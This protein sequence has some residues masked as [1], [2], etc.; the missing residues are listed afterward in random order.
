MKLIRKSFFRIS[1]LMNL[2]KL[3]FLVQNF[4]FDSTMNLVVFY[5]LCS[6]TYAIS[7]YRCTFNSFCIH[8]CSGVSSFAVTEPG[9]S[10]PGRKKTE[11]CFVSFVGL[12]KI[13]LDKLPVGLGPQQ[14]AR[15]NSSFLS[16]DNLLLIFKVVTH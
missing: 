2:C 6:N 5:V 16:R 4:S 15:E 1:H 9:S 7:V 13:P 8:T 3:Y 11:C 12:G 10:T 14:M